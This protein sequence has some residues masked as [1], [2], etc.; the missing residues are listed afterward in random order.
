M[1][2]FS[3]SGTRR[4]A[5]FP[6]LPLEKAAQFSGETAGNAGATSRLKR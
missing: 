5:V 1:G 6:G 4:R 2:A 3:L